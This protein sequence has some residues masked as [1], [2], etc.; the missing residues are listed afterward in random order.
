MLKQLDICSKEEG[1]TTDTLDEHIQS[2]LEEMRQGFDS[3]MFSFT[4]LWVGNSNEAVSYVQDILEYRPFDKEVLDQLARLLEERKCW[5]EALVVLDKLIQ[6]TKEDEAA[7]L[8]Y[9]LRHVYMD[10]EHV[11][12]L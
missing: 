12:L 4:S 7:S 10:L 3:G 6:L 9:L 11:Q 5:K 1:V 8:E 2:I